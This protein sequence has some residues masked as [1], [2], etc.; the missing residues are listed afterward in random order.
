MDQSQEVS[1]FKSAGSRPFPNH[2]AGTKNPSMPIEHLV[3]IMQENHSFDNY[4]GKLNQGQFYGNQIDGIKDDFFNTDSFK[5]KYF[6]Y[7]SET[8]CLRCP[9]HQYHQMHLAW[10]DGKN[11]GFVKHTGIG[12]NPGFVMGYYTDEDI[13]FYYSLANTFSVADRY[14]A[15]VLTGTQANR[16]YFLSGTSHGTVENVNIPFSHKNIFQL[17]NEY[18]ISWKYYFEGKGYLYL[19][20]SFLNKNRDKIGNFDDY[21]RDLKNNQ[22]PTVAFIDSPWYVSDEHPSGGN[23]QKGQAW[24]ADKIIALMES[25][26]WKNSALF[27]TYDE[28]GGYFDHVPPPPAC[29]P[30]DVKFA[31]VWKPDRLGFRVPFIAVSPFA[32]RHYVSH[33]VY[34]HTSILKFIETWYN[35]PALTRRD[36]NANNLMDLFDFNNR[37]LN[38]P[39]LK[40]A[41]VDP[42]RECKK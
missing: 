34:D 9:L 39:P 28:G 6:P 2:P 38:F 20:K 7:H 16:L 22:L 23:I 41:F 32:K 30:D 18:N 13:P 29:I 37:K 3:V 36:A 1:C 17:L 24:T 12:K 14:F 4:F 15:S 35:L 21:K 25:D 19:F 5:R 40:K 31:R 33:I 27:L 42:K 11:D 26:S 8:L 10:N